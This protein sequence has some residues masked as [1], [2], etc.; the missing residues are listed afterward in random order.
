M[1][2]QLR[3][4]LPALFAGSVEVLAGLKFEVAQVAAVIH[5]GVL[6][7]HSCGGCLNVRFCVGIMAESAGDC[8]F[9]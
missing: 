7:A 9:F 1:L 6:L 5:D 3:C 2:H 8:M 4:A